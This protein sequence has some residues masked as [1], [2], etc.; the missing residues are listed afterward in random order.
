MTIY[1]APL[2]SGLGDVIVTV[3]LLYKSI[4]L[5]ET[6]LVARSPRQEGLTQA[7]P[8]LAG[9]I[10]EPDLKSMQLGPLDRY[11][12]LR[13]HRLQ[14]EYVWGGPEFAAD[15]PDYRVSDILQ[16]MATDFGFD[17]D[18]KL[19]VPLWFERRPDFSDKTIIVPGTTTASKTWPTKYWLR[20]IALLKQSGAQVCMVGEPE[21]SGVVQDLIES[22][23][24]WEPTLAIQDA[25]NIVSSADSV[26]SVDTGL[27]HV[28]VQQ[29]IPTV[30]FFQGYPVYYRDFPN[31]F[32][33]FSRPCPA[34]C[35]RD[36]EDAAPNEKIE[37]EGFKWFDGTFGSCLA[38]PGM[39]CMDSITPD[40]VLLQWKNACLQT[41]IH[42]TA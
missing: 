1:I 11:L 10:R 36:L 12:N 42:N 15:Y 37:Y 26:I 23:V 40:M 19:R 31:C 38:D 6:C 30:A 8:G 13:T 14:T 25:I 18:F 24:P 35:L 4:E 29:G 22:D 16:V 20:L 2:G 39:S 34:S 28:A 33:L 27:M 32:P 41:S 21:R 3:P 5:G 7:I 17:V 9:T